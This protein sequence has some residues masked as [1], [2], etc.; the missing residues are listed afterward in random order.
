METNAHL[1]FVRNLNLRVKKE[2]KREKDEVEG[3][4]EDSQDRSNC[5][6]V[7]WH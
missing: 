1:D 2:K 7:I 6:R 5:G 3:K 4:L